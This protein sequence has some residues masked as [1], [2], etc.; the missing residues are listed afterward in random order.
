MK[1]LVIIG[2][3]PAG[4]T[5]AIY[6]KRAG[7]DL[8]VIEKF[9]PGGQ[10]MN[11]YEVENFPGFMDPVTGF[12]LMQSMEAQALRFGTQ[13]ESADISSFEKRNDGTFAVKGSGGELFESRAVI[14]AM[15]SSF[16]L[17]GVPG[18]KEFTGMGVSYCA[19]CDGA[20]FKDKVT[21]VIG[22]GNTALEE[23]LFLTRFA[24]KVYL[25]HRRDE[26]R[27]DKLLQDRVFSNEKIVPM[28]GYLPESIHGT[29]KVEYIALK[30][31]S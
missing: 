3:G 20:F 18:E 26:C 4:L 9:A 22:G 21:A 30:N 11:T 12:Q 28:L 2:A 25:I 31:V 7:L 17:L 16:R 14:L 13:I 23:A 27:G 24:S 1:D 10:V 19:T 6:G 15:G 29:A 8:V 5:A